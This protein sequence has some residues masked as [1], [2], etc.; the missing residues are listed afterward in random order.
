[1]VI[2][3]LAW[4]L[5]SFRLSFAQD[6]ANDL[7]TAYRD[8]TRCLVGPELRGASDA[9]ISC[10]CRDALLDARYVYRTYLLTSKDPR[11]RGAYL[12]LEHYATQMC[13]KAHDTVRVVSD[14]EWR[15]TGPDVMR[16]YPPDDQI[17]KLTPDANGFRTVQYDVRVTYR[18]PQGHAMKV[19]KFKALERMPSDFKTSACPAGAVC[20]K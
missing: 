11:L 6:P 18:D 2:A 19:E 3:V 16:L 7:D 5:V 15:W 13:G 17:E 9:P 10:Y 20:P 1:M 8:E 12:T 4:V 14:T